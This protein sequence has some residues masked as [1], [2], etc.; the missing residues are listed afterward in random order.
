MSSGEFSFFLYSFFFSLLTS[1]WMSSSLWDQNNYSL[2]LSFFFFLSIALSLHLWFLTSPLWPGSMNVDRD[3]H[4]QGG[5]QPCL[6]SGSSPW[7]QISMRADNGTKNE[8]NAVCQPR[9]SACHSRPFPMLGVFHELR[10]T[11]KLH[12]KCTSAFLHQ[13]ITRTD[14]PPLKIKTNCSVFRIYQ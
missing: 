10:W 12:F 14:P 4:M 6:A 13:L 3:R 8:N 7:Q 1:W 11:R 2:S 5:Q 9:N